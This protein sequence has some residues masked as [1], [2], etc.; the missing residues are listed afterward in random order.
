MPPPGCRPR[1]P[2]RVERPRTFRPQLRAQLG[3]ADPND[4]Q[5]RPRRMPATPKKPPKSQPHVSDAISAAS[6]TAEKSV[7][8]H[9]SFGQLRLS[10][11]TIQKTIFGYRPWGEESLQR[12][13]DPQLGG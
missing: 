9:R 7:A 6:V 5:P 10:N 1:F 3:R 2:A 13:K 11:A 4:G 8:N 12:A